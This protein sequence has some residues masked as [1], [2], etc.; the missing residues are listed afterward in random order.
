MST[1]TLTACAALATALLYLISVPIGSLGHLPAADASGVVVLSFLD[2]HRSGLLA[3]SALNGIAWCAL[4][5]VAFAG[6]RTLVH[7]RARVAATVALIC[8]GVEAALIGVGLVFGAL[9]AFVAPQLAPATAKLLGDGLTIGTSAS[10]WP[11]VPCAIALAIAFRAHG[12]LARG[13]APLALLVAVLHA[14]AAV[15]FARSGAFSPTGIA[16][17]A[18]PAFALLMATLGLALIRRP[19]AAP[20]FGDV[21]PAGPARP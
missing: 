13:V 12:G 11:T 1:R 9:G 17:A 6:L 5:P 3:A 10:A 14:I 7:Q 19:A 18:P 2:E 8:A 16:L 15:S 4:M 20:S 21:V